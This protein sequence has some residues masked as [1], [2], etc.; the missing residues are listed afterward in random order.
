MGGIHGGFLDPNFKGKP[1][2]KTLANCATCHDKADRGWFGRVTYEISD[3]TFRTDDVDM[4]VSMPVPSW[5]RIGG[6][7]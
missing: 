6:K 5:M 4:S 2:V 7:K 1:L 3:E